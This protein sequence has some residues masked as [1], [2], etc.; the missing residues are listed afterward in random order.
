MSIFEIRVYHIF[1]HAQ[2]S[3]SDVFSCF[4]STSWRNRVVDV[5]L[6]VFGVVE[7]LST[8]AVGTDHSQYSDMRNANIIIIFTH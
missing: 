3:V 8:H 7:W 5:Q 4:A 1:S 2:K 6:E